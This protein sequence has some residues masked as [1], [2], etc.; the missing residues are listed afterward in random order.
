MSSQLHLDGVRC[1]R[2]I[3]VNHRLER[4]HCLL[5]AMYLRSEMRFDT[6]RG[7]ESGAQP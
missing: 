1:H 7:S 4:H 2:R 5:R 3:R 6:L